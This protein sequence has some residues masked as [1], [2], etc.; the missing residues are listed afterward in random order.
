MK[1]FLLNQELKEFDTPSNI[2]KFDSA[3]LHLTIL[4]SGSSPHYE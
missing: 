1:A 4:D 3:S 2:L